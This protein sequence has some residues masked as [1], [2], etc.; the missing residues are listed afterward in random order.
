LVRQGFKAGAWKGAP[1]RVIPGV[2]VPA[3]QTGEANVRV[4]EG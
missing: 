2:T 4:A 1:A 3:V